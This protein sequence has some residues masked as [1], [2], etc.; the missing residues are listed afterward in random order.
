M[1]GVWGAWDVN[2]PLLRCAYCGYVLIRQLPDRVQ[3]NLGTLEAFPDTGK[4][5]AQCRRC[6]RHVIVTA[7][8][9]RELYLLLMDVFRLS[10]VPIGADGSAIVDSLQSCVV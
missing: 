9:D 5:T 1:D 2:R 4:I 7:G 10:F 3:F 6:P 8:G